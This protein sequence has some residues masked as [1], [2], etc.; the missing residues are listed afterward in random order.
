MALSDKQFYF[1]A[2]AAD[3]SPKRILVRIKNG[4]AGFESEG[5]LD[6]YQNGKKVFSRRIRRD[7][8]ASIRGILAKKP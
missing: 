1:D 2:T 5:Y 7:K 4:L 6:Y 3:G 8:Y